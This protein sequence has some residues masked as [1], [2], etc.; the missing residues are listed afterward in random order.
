VKPRQSWLP[1]HEILARRY[2]A[3]HRGVVGEARQPKLVAPVCLSVPVYF[4]FDAF[5]VLSQDDTLFS[6]GNIGS[7]RVTISQ[8]RDFFRSI[9]FQWV[10][11]NG[12]FRP[13]ER[14]EIIF[15]RNAEVLI[16]RRQ[17]L[18]PALKFIACRS[19]AERQTLLHL[20]P[21][22][23]RLKWERLISIDTQGLYE[24]KWTYVEEVVT[25]SESPRVVMRF[26]PGTTT[27]GPFHLRFEYQEHDG[28]KPRS[29]ERD[30]NALPTRMEIDMVK[31]ESGVATLWLDDSLAFQDTLYFGDIP[32]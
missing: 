16:P 18:P 24:R 27:P 15:R 8:E 6:N 29:L 5:K 13:E 19:A 25:V 3:A 10:F 32:F 23:I 4:C 7:H 2:S 28:S 31:A 17:V 11:H 26:N 22:R 30:I 12:Y 14:D 20:L 9:P 1:C 21:A